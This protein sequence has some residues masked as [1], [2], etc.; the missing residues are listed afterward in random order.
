MAVVPRQNLQTE[1]PV[2]ALDCLCAQWCPVSTAMTKYD[3]LAPV[4]IQV[5]VI[6]EDSVRLNTGPSALAPPHL[7]ASEL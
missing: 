7:T 4:K 5:L 2:S 6:N 1:T 3:P